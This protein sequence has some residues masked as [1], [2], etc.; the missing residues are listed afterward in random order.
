MDYFKNKDYNREEA[1]RWIQYIARYQPQIDKSIE[2]SL[3]YDFS[4]PD[5]KYNIVDKMSI[6]KITNI[7][8][9]PIKIFSDYKIHEY[10]SLY[11]VKSTTTE[12][13]Y[14]YIGSGTKLAVLNFASYKNP[15]GMFM[16]GS[17]AQEESLCHE[18]TLY[19]VLYKCTPFY[20][21][22]R[23]HLNN[24]FYDHRV[25][26]TPNIIFES[27]DH[28]KQ[29][30][31]DVITCAFPNLAPAL[32][33]GKYINLEYYLDVLEHRIE[34]ILYTAYTEDVDTLI[35]GAIGCGV[36][37]NSPTVVADIFAKQI[38]KYD[39]SFA[40]I[41]FAIP[42]ENTYNIFKDIFTTTELKFYEA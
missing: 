27:K 4:N 14:N 8:N 6:P 34:S 26:Y 2:E 16:N 33:Y 35:L 40:N 41:A 21:Y 29:R 10:P 37:K 30:V 13:I 28:S 38:K 15:G 42:D 22:N 9:Y 25:L 39:H 32:R 12:A 1:E 24:S 3:I 23:D 11:L 7:F 18:S 36:F 20:E 31:A 5:S 17:M 19:L